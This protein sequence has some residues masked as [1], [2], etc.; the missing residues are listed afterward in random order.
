MRMGRFA[1]GR[2]QSPLSTASLLLGRVKTEETRVAA[3]AS[4]PPPST[5]C[6]RAEHPK[7]G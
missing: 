7:K 3:A 6:R 5:G 1:V 4:A 2:N